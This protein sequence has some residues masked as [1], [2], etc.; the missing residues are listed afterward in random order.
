MKLN[1]RW[2]GSP[3][4]RRLVLRRKKF[5]VLHWMVGD[6]DS[7]DH[8]FR[9][10]RSRVSTQYGIE[11]NKIHK[12]VRERDYAFGSGTT[13]A[14]TYGISI[15]HSG[16]ELLRDGTRRKP[17]PET[18]ET[19]ARL[20]ASIAARWRL[21]TLKVGKNV[22]PHSHFKA[23]ECPG[24]LDIEWIVARANAINRARRRI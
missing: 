24:S 12:Y 8:R 2:V 11:N 9:D 17:S 23:T 21:G 3:N 16:G 14:N 4:Y 10:P 6:L 1:V 22:Y 15:E 20:C 7:T 18:H 5:I 13:Y 19:S